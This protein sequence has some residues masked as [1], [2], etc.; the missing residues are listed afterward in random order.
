[1]KRIIL[2]LIALFFLL[3]SFAYGQTNFSSIYSNQQS[4]EANYRSAERAEKYQN[5]SAARAIAAIKKLEQNVLVYHSLDEFE[6]GG[7]LALVSLETFKDHLQHV[8][9]EV[10]MILPHLPQGRLKTHIANALASYRDGVFWWQ[11][12]YQPRVVHASALQFAEITKTP[13][14]LVLTSTMPYTVAI[15]WRQAR[16]FLQRAEMLM[17]Q[18]DRLLK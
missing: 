2:A 8:T 13:S 14:D 17:S 5:N 7:K 11:K 15:H 9:A 12:I 1:M 3:E 6:V 4:A 16:K 18:R 10:E